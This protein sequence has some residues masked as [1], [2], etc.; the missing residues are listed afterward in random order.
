MVLRS[1]FTASL[2]PANPFRFAELDNSDATKSCKT[3]SARHIGLEGF[4]GSLAH[5]CKGFQNC[6]K[7]R[8]VLAVKPDARP[9]HAQTR[10][11][12]ARPGIVLQMFCF[13]EIY[14]ILQSADHSCVQKPPSYWKTFL[15]KRHTGDALL[16]GKWA[17]NH[18]SAI[19]HLE[20]F[21]LKA[22]VV[23][24]LSNEQHQ[25]KSALA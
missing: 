10:Q 13:K 4:H 17:A 12:K 22:C 3:T 1:C 11:T 7:Q 15:W 6:L 25:I 20:R 9:A 16:P 23:W 21:L 18:C 2:E 8:H 5:Q 24:P 14:L 19:S